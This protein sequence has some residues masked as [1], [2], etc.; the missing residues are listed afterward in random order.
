MFLLYT[1]VL[2]TD[3]GLIVNSQFNVWRNTQYANVQVKLPPDFTE[4]VCGLFGFPNGNY[5]DEFR[6][7]NGQIVS[8]IFNC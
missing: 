5:A 7:K 4:R 2:S 8:N 3:F 6:M 1:K